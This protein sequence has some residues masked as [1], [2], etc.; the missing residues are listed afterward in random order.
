M[1]LSPPTLLD[2]VPSGTDAT[3]YATASVSPTANA[4]LVG[5]IWNSKASAPDAGTPGNGFAISGLWTLVQDIT[6]PSD[7]ARLQVW[8]ALAS[9]TPGSGTFSVDFGANTQIGGI[10]G[11]AEWTGFDTSTPI[12]QS[13]ED[14][15]PAGSTSGSITLPGA[16]AAATSQCFAIIGVNSTGAITPNGSEIEIVEEG[17]TAPNRRLQ[18]Q[19]EVNDTNSTWTF[20]SSAA[21]MIAMEIKE[22]VGIVGQPSDDPPIGILGRGA[23]W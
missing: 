3:S 12:P 22:A 19:Y 18:A 6:S 10:I 2:N 23:G 4:L 9:G 7:N 5:W 11:I 14:T 15:A 21:G 16:L 20:T 1:A 13:A 17:H 8:W